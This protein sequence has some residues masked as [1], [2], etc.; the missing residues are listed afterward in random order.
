MAYDALRRLLADGHSPSVA[1]LPDGS[2]D[3]FC[4]LSDGRGGTIETRETFG[5][6]VLGDR[7]S[8][9][10]Q[11]ETSEPGGQAVNAATQL[12]ALGADVA[13]YGHIDDPVFDDLPFETVSMG[14]PAEVYAFNFTDQD[15]MFARHPTFAEWSLDDLRDLAPLPEIFGVEAVACTNWVSTPNMGAAFHRLGEADLPR[16][17]FV[18][19]PG[20]VVKRDVDDLKALLNAL[21]ALQDT[22]DVIYNGNRAEV[23]ET[24]AVIEGRFEDDLDRLAAIREA[25]GISATV[26]HDRAEALVATADERT[27]VENYNAEEAVRHTGGGDRFTGGLTHALACGWDWEP[28]LACGNACA[29]YYVK[30]GETATTDALANLIDDR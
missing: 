5:H 27:R 8:F 20:D 30:T 15:V 21:G 6:D 4:T 7:S 24:A 2:V 22:F 14:E 28:A 1:T 9:R 12:H 11:I 10:F 13:C 19:D 25:A 16:V 18:L 26:I 3:H 17:P 29:V 23:R